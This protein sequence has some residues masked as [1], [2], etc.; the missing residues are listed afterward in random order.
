MV[1]SLVAQLLAYGLTAYA[2]VLF[3]FTTEDNIVQ[4]LLIGC[5]IFLGLLIVKIFEDDDFRSE[6]LDE[7]SN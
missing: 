2:L 7:N 4:R 6:N 5:A 3:V 1:S